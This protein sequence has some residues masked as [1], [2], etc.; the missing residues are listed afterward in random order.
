MVLPQGTMPG[1]EV[2]RRAWWTG[3]H[4]K[5]VRWLLRWPALAAART[6]LKGPSDFQ[7]VLGQ[8]LTPG[9]AALVLAAQQLVLQALL[10]FRS[11]PRLEVLQPVLGLMQGV[12]G[13]FG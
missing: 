2:S 13:V 8:L 6:R 10:G 11:N 3:L 7:D 9:Q 1:W 4:S 5:A 12:L